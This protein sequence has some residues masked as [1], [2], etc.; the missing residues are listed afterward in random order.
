[1]TKVTNLRK[2][3]QVLAVGKPN[4]PPVEKDMLLHM[5][6]RGKLEVKG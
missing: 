3:T 5:I 6:F 1:M 2:Q 4:N